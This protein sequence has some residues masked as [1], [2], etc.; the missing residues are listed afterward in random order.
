MEKS[1][2]EALI[3]DALSRVYSIDLTR[4]RVIAPDLSTAIDRAEDALDALGPDAD[5]ETAL[6][7]LDVW[8]YALQAGARALAGDVPPAPWAPVF[9][10]GTRVLHVAAT[11]ASVEDGLRRLAECGVLD[12]QVDTETA[13]WIITATLARR[14]A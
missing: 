13:T 5:G 12:D 9:E 1:K 11:C 6:S 8:W 3:V 7:A 2:I 4:L 10:P 14:R